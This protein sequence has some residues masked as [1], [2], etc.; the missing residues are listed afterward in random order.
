MIQGCTTIAIITFSFSLQLKECSVFL[1]KNLAVFVRRLCSALSFHSRKS[2][3][4]SS[5][6]TSWSSTKFLWS[7]GLFSSLFMY[8]YSSFCLLFSSSFFCSTLIKS[9]LYKITH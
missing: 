3:F 5:L 7:S 6:S 8:L 2:S 1:S 4:S 9:S